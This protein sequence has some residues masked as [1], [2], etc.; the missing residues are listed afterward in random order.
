MVHTENGQRGGDEE[1][2]EEDKYHVT[3]HLVVH[4]LE[5]APRQNNL[6]GKEK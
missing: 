4:S 1:L 5:S 6:R 2:G 3:D